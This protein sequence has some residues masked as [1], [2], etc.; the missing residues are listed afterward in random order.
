MALSIRPLAAHHRRDA[1][2]CGVPS[3]NDWLR[4]TAAQHRRKNISVTH[5]LADEAAPNDVI[6]YYALSSCVVRSVDLPAPLRKK[7]P[8]SVP[9]IKLGRLAVDLRHAGQRH[10]ESMLLDAILRAQQVSMQISVHALFVDALDDG[11]ARFYRHYGFVA[12]PDLPLTL[13]L[14]LTPTPY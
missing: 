11:V 13:V 12:F 14:S 3:L 10:G 6:A 4:N 8:L 2:D 5:V 7:L 1:F 9:G